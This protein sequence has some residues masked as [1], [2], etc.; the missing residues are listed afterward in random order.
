MAWSM[1]RP[2]LP[3]STDGTA[4]IAVVVPTHNRASL[5]PRLVSALVAQEDVPG[6]EIVLVDDA[7]T[8]ATPDVLANLLP[9]LEPTGQAIRLAHNRGPATARNIGWRTASAPLI[10]FLDDDCVPQPGWLASL[11]ASLA[12][13]DIV[14]GRTLPDPEQRA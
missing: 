9:S 6:A 3:P 1:S 14:Q 11:A 13:A 7:S 8:D 2:T 4:P 10:A 12:D 5:L